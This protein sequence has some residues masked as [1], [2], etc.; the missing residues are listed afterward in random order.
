MDAK[1]KTKALNLGIKNNSGE[2]IAMTDDDFTVSKDWIEKIIEA[3]QNN[4]DIGIV[5]GSVVYN[6]ALTEK[7]VGA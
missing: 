2:I 7:K 1:G 3:F 4:P 6:R 5:F